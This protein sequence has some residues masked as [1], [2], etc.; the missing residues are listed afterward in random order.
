MGPKESDALLEQDGFHWTE[1]NWSQSY[2]EKQ[3]SE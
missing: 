1:F 2:K 3:D